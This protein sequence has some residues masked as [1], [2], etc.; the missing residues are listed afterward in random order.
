MHTPPCGEASHTPSPGTTH[1]ARRP[2]LALAAALAAGVVA[3][4]PTEPA[5]DDDSA[6]AIDDDDDATEPPVPLADVLGVATLTNV[7][8]PEGTDYVDLGGAFGDFASVD[9]ALLSPTAYMGTWD[10][11]AGLWRLDLGSWP[12]PPLGSD[13]VVDL[14]DYVPWMP[15]D[16]TWWDAGDRIA[17]GPYLAVRYVNHDEG[18]LGYIVDDPLNPGG[19]AWV[20]GGSVS[21]ATSGGVDIV[22]WSAPAAP[23]P[24]DMEL[25]VPLPGATVET[26]SAHEYTVEWNPQDDGAT[27]MVV[28]L[29]GLN[30]SYVA[31]VEDSGSHTLPAAVLHDDF[32]PGAVQL[33]VSRLVET[34]L[35]H[36]QGDVIF[37][38]RSEERAE[39]LLLDDLVLRPAYGSAGQT[40]DVDLRWFTGSIDGATTVDLGDGTTVNSVTPDGSDPQRALVNVTL[41]AGAEVGTRSVFV[42]NGGE[43]IDALDAFT[44]LDLDPADDCAAAAAI[45]PIGEGT[46][47]S[48]TDGLANTLA[49]GYA[50]VDWSLNASDAVYEVALEAG[51]PVRIVAEMPDPGDAALVLLDTCGDPESAI[52]CADNGFEG[53]PEEILFTPETSGTYYVVVDGYFLSGF[54]SASSPFELTVETGEAASPVDPPWVVPGTSP[55][56]SV[57]GTWG[58]VDAGDVDL[59]A[60]ITVDSA[61]VGAA[62]SLE[63]TVDGGATVGPRTLSVDD[64]GVQT[65]DDAV[66]VTSLPASDSCADADAWGAITASGAATTAWAAGT[67]NLYDDV[68]CFA[69]G[70][71]GAEVVHALDLTAGQTLGAFLE[72][73]EDTQLYVLT[74]CSDVTSCVDEASSDDGFGG[75]P[76]EIV[77]WEV[78][79]TGRYYLVVDLFEQPFGPAWEYAL[80][81]TVTDP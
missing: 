2:W 7:R 36:P 40:V 58:A 53:D 11:D 48:T 39:L 50:C 76:E 62:L 66:Y 20:P 79:A 32:G 35:E 4:C 3:G 61:T 52:A 25:V 81:L 9:T 77:A 1:P 64:G 15:E 5:D 37:R 74:D 27:V 31:H 65:F 72:S 55:T 30:V 43:F 6:V 14:F 59:G 24:A 69:W 68:G 10:A 28:L 42:S 41:D 70:S 21:F 44:I 78:P 34:V 46:F 29:Q 26:P 16:Q 51:V 63:V 23:L 80:T 73:A 67:T 33:I 71:P 17:A 49:S 45:G 13:L 12:I 60:G 75:D 56:L 8:Q 57:A 19:N 38:A 47:T 22:D 54:G 18:T